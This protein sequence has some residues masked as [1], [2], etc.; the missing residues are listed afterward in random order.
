[1]CGLYFALQSGQENWQLCYR[2]CQIQVV[3]HS[4]DL[5]YL[6]YSE[7]TFKNNQGGLK[8][9]SYSKNMRHYANEREPCSSFQVV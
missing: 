3:E 7:D 2:P 5:P 8:G 4:G 6:L 9:Q 1:M